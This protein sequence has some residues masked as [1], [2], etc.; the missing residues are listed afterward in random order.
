MNGP[1]KKVH[2]STKNLFNKKVDVVCVVGHNGNVLAATTN[3]KKYDIV[4]KYEEFYYLYKER[5]KVSEAAKQ[6][7]TTEICGIK[8]LFNFIER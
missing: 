1:P 5:Y 2:R 3:N 8:G 4:K 7:A 6:M